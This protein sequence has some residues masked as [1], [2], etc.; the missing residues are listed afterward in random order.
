MKDPDEAYLVDAVRSFSTTQTREHDSPFGCLCS[1]TRKYSLLV[2]P[3]RK[4]ACMAAADVDV[5]AGQS[6]TLPFL[7]SAP[8]KNR[9]GPPAAGFGAGKGTNGMGR[10]S[11]PGVLRLRA[12]SAVSCDELVRRFAQD[13][14]FVGVLKKN[15]P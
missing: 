12:P 1:L 6:K 2:T 8:G 3:T 15:I 10:T 13:D 14:D 11:G 7:L 9:G 4:R 5:A